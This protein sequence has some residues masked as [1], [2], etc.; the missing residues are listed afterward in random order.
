M[1]LL[2]IVGN[3]FDLHHGMQ[4]SYWHFGE[5][6]KQHHRALRMLMDEY[7]PTYESFFWSNLEEGLA[8]FDAATLV[9]NSE[10]Y[11]V[12]YA[13]EDW[14]D[15]FHHDF[16]WELDRITRAVSEELLKAF[17]EWVQTIS[18]PTRKG[19]NVAPVRINPNARF[20]NFNYTNTLQQLYGVSDSHVWHIH[21]AAGQLD[22]LI[23][24]HAWKP[25]G[26]EKWTERVDPE[27]D[28]PRYIE[29]TQI[30]DRY[31]AQ[32][33]KPTEKIIFDNSKRFAALSD[34]DAIH[35]LGH[36]LSDVDLPYLREVAKHARPSA[37][38]RISFH[39]TPTPLEAQFRKLAW[40]MPAQYCL[41]ADV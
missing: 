31:F 41:L 13:A 22:R 33:F 39:G 10:H 35:V 32:T 12:S 21:G 4:T 27:S 6:L 23:L 5:F 38:W 28:D 29:G 9:D 15:A 11:L 7:F 19:L 2:Y 24:G 3:G 36:S 18:I 16:Q 34:V 37:Q 40:Q 26:R 14:S 25:K 20:I 30:I 17:S 8:H 1:S